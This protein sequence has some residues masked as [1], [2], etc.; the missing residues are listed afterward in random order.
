VHNLITVLVAFTLAEMMFAMGLR[1][2]FRRSENAHAINRK[3]ILKAFAGNYLVI[4]AVTFLAVLCFRV[5]PQTATGLLILGVAPAAPYALPFTVIARGNLF[6]STVLMVL[7]AGTSV[8]M[9]PL[10][11]HLL[12]PVINAGEQSMAFDPL[13]L[14]GSLFFMQL[15]PLCLGLVLNHRKPELARRMVRPAA[16]GSKI[17]NFFMIAAIAWLQFNVIF[18]TGIADVPVMLFLVASGIATGWLLGHPGRENRISMSIIT[19]MRN[20]SLGI[21]IAATAFPGSPVLTSVLVYSFV[22]GLSVLAYAFLLRM[23]AADRH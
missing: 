23:A 15:I 20:F 17:L 12:V 5:S 22:A 13:K 1:I 2:D 19:A 18:K 4:P 3:L 9:A 16:M 8:L 6:L 10:L 11:L 7:L 21:G 14:A